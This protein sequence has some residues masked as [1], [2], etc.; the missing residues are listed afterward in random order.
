LIKKHTYNENTYVIS[1]LLEISLTILFDSASRNQARVIYGLQLESKPKIHI[2]I[3]IAIRVNT[4]AEEL[5]AK[6][7]REKHVIR[8]YP[9]TNFSVQQVIHKW[10]KI[11]FILSNGNSNMKIRIYS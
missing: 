7:V 4:G 2:A 11:S 10:K 6:G 1:L 8:T 3:A 5:A 9:V